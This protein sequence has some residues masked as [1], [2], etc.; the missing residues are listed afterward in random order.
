[1]DAVF[2]KLTLNNLMKNIV[3][4]RVTHAEVFIGTAQLVLDATG[5]DSN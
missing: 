5:V 1:M 4:Q 2:I 3:M